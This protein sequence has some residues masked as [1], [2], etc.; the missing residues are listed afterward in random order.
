MTGKHLSDQLQAFCVMV[1]HEGCQA[2][3]RIRKSG[4]RL[5]ARRHLFGVADMLIQE[6]QLFERALLFCG[7]TARHR[8][9]ALNRLL[10]VGRNGAWHV[11]VNGE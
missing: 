6:V 11:G 9:A 4:Q 5:R 7:E 10:N 1:K 2:D 3:R 8:V